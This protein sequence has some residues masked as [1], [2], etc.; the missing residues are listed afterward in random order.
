MIAFIQLAEDR[1][2]T[3]H[4]YASVVC[5]PVVLAI[6]IVLFALFL[7]VVTDRAYED[8]LVAA[9]IFIGLS[10]AL[11]IIVGNAGVVFFGQFAFVAVGAYTSGVLTV[12]VASRGFLLPDLPFWLAGVETSFPISVVAGGAVAAVVALV[13]SPV[14]VRVSGLAAAVVSL[15]LLYIISDVLKEARSITRGTQ[16]FANVPFDASLGSVGLALVLMALV[17]SGFKYS[18]W[19]L[20]ARAGRDA[21]VAANACGITRAQRLVPALVLSAALSGA[22]GA[23][24]AHYLTAF[25]PITFGIEPAI[26]V[27]MMCVLGGPSSVTGALVGGVIVAGWRELSRHLESGILIAGLQLPRLPEFGSLTLSLGLLLVLA[28]RP[29]GL[30][31]SREI[32]ILRPRTAW[33]ATDVGDVDL[34]ADRQARTMAP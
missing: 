25:S 19:G 32:Q 1:V 9:V 5:G 23:V 17:A 16:T 33:K 20:A 31:G 12:P 27:V 15:G 14:M 11:Q 6:G 8:V 4:G 2:Q 34:P 7:N 24:W 21:P 10:V 3:R 30:L 22:G 26:I 29:G 18:R 28:L 13:V